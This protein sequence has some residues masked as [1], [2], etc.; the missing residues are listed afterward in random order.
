MRRSLLIIIFCAL[1]NMSFAQGH[2]EFEKTTHDFGQ[3]KEVDGAAEYS[4]AFTNTGDQPIK[5]TRVKAS[6]GCTT[7]YWTKEEVLPGENGKI[8][9]RYNTR[10]RPGNFTKTLRVTSNADNPNV[11]LYIKGHVK[12]RPR[13]IA[14]DLPTK[15]GSMRVKYRSFNM[16]NMTTEKP[17]TK[18]FDVYNDSDSAFSFLPKEMDLPAHIQVSFEP[19]TLDSKKK[20]LIQITYDPEKKNDLGY[21]SDRIRLVTTDDAS[22]EKPMYVVATIEEY[23]PPM[24]EEELAQAP[25]LSINK[26]SHNFGEV[27]GGEII[28]TTFILENTGKQDLN[29]RKTKANCGCTVSN[30]PKETLAP[31]EKVNMEVKFNTK[32]RRGRQYKNVTIFSNDPKAP[33]Q[34]VTIKAE[35]N[36]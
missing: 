35:V 25:R 10:N 3:I 13:T 24:T 34:V 19:E 32:G 7:P 1:F 30:L 27:K 16:G 28:K 26:K 22:K 14:D 17:I 33:T 18:T 29:I 31:G 4:F 20:G 36:N 6:C 23:F 5:I 12:P 2:I 8:T 11:T 21:Q 15:L 9:A